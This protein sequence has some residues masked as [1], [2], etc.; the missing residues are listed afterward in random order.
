MR[1]VAVIEHQAQNLVHIVDYGNIRAASLT[2][3]LLQSFACLCKLF[4]Y[5]FKAF[6]HICYLRKQV[7]V[8]VNINRFARYHGN[9]NIKRTKLRHR[10]FK[11]VSYFSDFARHNRKRQLM[12]TRRK[13]YEIWVVILIGKYAFF[14][15]VGIGKAYFLRFLKGRF[16]VYFKASVNLCAEYGALT[17]HKRK[18]VITLFKFRGYPGKRFTVGFPVSAAYVVY[19]AVSCA[20]RRYLTTAVIALGS[21]PIACFDY[22]ILALNYY[23][24]AF[25]KV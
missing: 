16:T 18:A 17:V 4:V 8:A 2:S 5:C 1:C 19:N 7:V 10:L 9:I 11:Q 12:L 25:I 13:V 22:R 24:V 21:E 23:R 3:D 15:L 14:P 6:R 20:V